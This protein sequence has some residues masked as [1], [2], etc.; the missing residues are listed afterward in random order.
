VSSYQKTLLKYL[1]WLKKEQ[2]MMHFQLRV[3]FLIPLDLAISSLVGR[4]KILP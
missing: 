4:L 2:G 3:R 1:L